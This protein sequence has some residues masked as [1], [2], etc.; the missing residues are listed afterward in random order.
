MAAEPGGNHELG[1]SYET[2]TCAPMARRFD[3]VPTNSTVSQMAAGCH[4]VCAVASNGGS[5]MLAVQCGDESRHSICVLS[6][7]RA[8][9]GLVRRS[10]ANARLLRRLLENGARLGKQVPRHARHGRAPLV[11]AAA[12]GEAAPRRLTLR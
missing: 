1:T 12:F 3:F 8:C 11:Y 6:G 9:A 10:A 4:T 7:V 5:F 2:T